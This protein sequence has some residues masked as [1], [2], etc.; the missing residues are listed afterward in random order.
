MCCFAVINACDAKKNEK[1]ATDP[2]VNRAI[3]RN[4]RLFDPLNERP[5]VT[6]PSGLSPP[7]QCRN[8]PEPYRL[9]YNRQ[10]ET[11]SIHRRF[12]Y[13]RLRLKSIRLFEATI[14]PHSQ[15]PCKMLIRRLDQ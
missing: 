7:A 10:I 8:N 4:A 15:L 2:N 6:N 12:D 13:M 5:H 1:P 14:F 9:H 3:D 11:S